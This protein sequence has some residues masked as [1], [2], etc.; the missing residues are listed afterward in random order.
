MQRTTTTLLQGGLNLVTPAIAVP[1]G[2]AIAAVNY[3]PE[4]RGYKRIGGYERHDGRPKPSLARYF[5]LRFEAGDTLVE[6]GDVVT[7]ATSGATG[8]ALVDGIIEA[9][10]YG[11]SDAAGRLVL[12]NVVGVF[13]S[14]ED[15]E[16]SAAKV[17]ES[18]GTAIRSGADTDADNTTWR[19]A[20]IAAR[21]SVITAVPGSGPVRG[22][23]AYDGALYAFRDNVGATACVMHKATSSGWAAQALGHV[24]FFTTGSTRF[25]EG[26]ILTQGA[27]TAT[28]E[29]AVTTGGSYT[30]GD[31]TGYLVLSGITGGPFIAGAATSASGTASL[32]GAETANALPP[33][34]RYSFANENFTGAAAGFRMYATNGVGRGFEWDGA[35]FTPIRTGLSDA[36]D[37][38]IRVAAFA[39]HLFF[40][41]EGGTLLFSGIGDPLSYETTL[42]AGEIAFGA[43]ITDI[44]PSASTALIVFARNRVSFLVG[45]DAASFELRQLAD[46]AGAF[47]FTAQLVGS[48]IYLDD[49]GLRRMESTQAFGNFVM[50]TVTQAVTPLFEAKR[51][52]GVTAVASLRVREKDQ[53]RLFFSDGTGIT[54][55]FGR[56]RP[57]IIPFSI[58]VQV[59]CTSA[60]DADDNGQGEQLWFGAENGFVYE[61][62]VGTSFDGATIEAFL[63][64]PFNHIGTPSQ[65]KRWHK[66]TLELDAGPDTEIGLTA[67]FG[68]SNPNQPPSSEQSFDVSGGGGFWNEANWNEMFWSSPVQGT[69]EAY[70]GGIGQNV[71]ICVLSDAIHEEP[72]VLS[73]LTLNFTYRGLVR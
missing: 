41:F 64:L 13:V 44:L 71:S 32:T 8:I 48:P 52:A 47:A 26:E 22:V 36:L 58:P 46:D 9:G 19:R 39:N 72:H 16:V 11:T 12:Y 40:G 66:A 27:V 38:P 28:I 15:L 68:Y 61:M 54:I 65:R 3:E 2:Q 20:A 30:G 4:V 34:G 1:P 14:G 18:V 6:E 17:A 55:Y 10:A 37:K 35:V 29:R 57:E 24:V 60:S 42:G 5:V 25:E 7:G 59:S 63:R 69:A 21:R 43:Q 51:R 73:A 70:I 31:A 50:G 23:H 53:Y 56:E 33:G 62:N 49:A 45:S 67:E